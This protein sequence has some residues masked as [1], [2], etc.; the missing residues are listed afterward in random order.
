MFYKCTIESNSSR[1]RCYNV[2]STSAMHAAQCYGRAEDGET[3]TIERIRS[4][5]VLSRVKWDSS[6]KKYIRVTI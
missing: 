4:G 3:V 6:G 2:M 5:K 1:P